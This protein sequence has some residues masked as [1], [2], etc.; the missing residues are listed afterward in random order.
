MKHNTITIDVGT[1]LASAPC[2][3]RGRKREDNNEEI[4]YVSGVVTRI[5][6]NPDN[7]TQRYRLREHGTGAIIHTVWMDR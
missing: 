1:F 3:L 6:T 2:Q 5:I 7:G 4:E